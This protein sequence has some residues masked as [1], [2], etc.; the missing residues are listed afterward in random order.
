MSVHGVEPAGLRVNGPGRRLRI[1][2]GESDRWQGK[3]L[4]MA[5]LEALKRAGLRGATVLRGVAGFGAHSR[6]HT[7]AIERLSADLPL[8]VEVVD[9]PEQI[10]HALGVVGPMVRE[11][12]ITVDEVQIVKY[13]HRYLQPLPGD[14][15]VRE[16]MTP[17]VVTVRPDTPLAEVMDLLIGKMYK[18]V[19]VVDAERRVVGLITDGDL[20][21]RGGLK[22]R[23]SVTERLDRGTLA[24]QLA[25]MR[26]AGLSARDVMTAPVHTVSADDSLAHAASRM[27]QG[28]LKRL[29]VLDAAGRL[30]GIL[31][32]VDVLRTVQAAQVT[33]YHAAPPPA[34]G[35]TV[36]DVMQP[37]V[38][39]VPLDAELSDIAAQM[40]R[41]ALK[42]VIVVDAAG[43][44]V[45]SINDGDLVARVQP[46][47]RPGLLRLLTR[48]TR[49]ESLPPVSAAK[50][51]TP[52]VLSGPAGTPIA[53]AVQRMLAEKR[54]RFVVVD[55]LGRPIGIVDRQLLLRAVA[56]EA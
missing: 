40:A 12:L 8:I 17:A 53:A 56:G 47:A 22:Q 54:K 33:D 35:Q 52:G 42:R 36:G 44:A 4:Y 28:G 11:G 13:T 15:L 51:M 43:K 41:A 30:T 55:D 16:V 20:L 29:P 48:R 21:A 25:E 24:E 14:R 26:R 32:R 46:E 6:I 1:Y 39:T 9:T 34:A 10:E 3:A 49:Q 45:G 38:P 5:L 27:A 31:S 2:L 37:E 19:P 18:A 7:A 23:L 50:L